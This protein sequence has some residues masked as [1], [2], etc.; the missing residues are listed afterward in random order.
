MP[1]ASGTSC[2]RSAQVTLCGPASAGVFLDDAAAA[3]AGARQDLN[4]SGLPLPNSFQL[5]TPGELIKPGRPVVFLRPIDVRTSRKPGAMAQALSLP[6]VCTSL[7]QGG[8]DTTQLLE[9]QSAVEGWMRSRLAGNED[10]TAP[11][12]IRQAYANLAACEAGP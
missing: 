5:A 1:T 8:P 12:S 3:L 10:A 4:S 11:P 9:L 7:L 2:S 6:R